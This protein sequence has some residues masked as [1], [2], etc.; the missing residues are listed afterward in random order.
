M[1]GIRPAFRTEKTNMQ[2]AYS[3][4]TSRPT[5]AQGTNESRVLLFLYVIFN[6]QI[7]S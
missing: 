1:L 7:I 4:Y 6:P 3:E 5:S 2:F